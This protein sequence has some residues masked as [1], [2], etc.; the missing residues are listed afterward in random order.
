MYKWANPY[1]SSVKCVMV[2][3]ANASSIAWIPEAENFYIMR[4]FFFK[5]LTFIRSLES[6]INRYSHFL[7][8]FWDLGPLVLGAGSRWKEGWSHHA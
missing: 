2:L 1:A 8:T 4:F 3:L 5:P 6:L 7:V